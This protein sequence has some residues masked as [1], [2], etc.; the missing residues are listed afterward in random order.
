MK[1]NEV[2]NEGLNIDKKT[3][4]G[5][6]ILLVVILFVA[7]LLTQ[8]LPRGQFELDEN[9]SV[10]AGT[11]TPMNDYRMPIWKIAA[12]PVLAFTTSNA[13]TGLAIIAI[14]MRCFGEVFK[15]LFLIILPP[16]HHYLI[17]SNVSI[18]A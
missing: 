10:I 11:Y 5:I 13:V 3:I 14:I 6:S 7:G 12:S 16:A 15:S 9:G 18:I 17:F 2:K 8:V 1:Q 4:A